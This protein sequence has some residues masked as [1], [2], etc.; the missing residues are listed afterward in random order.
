MLAITLYT[1]FSTAVDHLAS[2]LRSRNQKGQVAAEYLG[3]LVVV[4]GIITVLTTQTHLGQAIGGKLT[5][6]VTNIF[7]N[8]GK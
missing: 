4:A 6:V 7:G 8:G 3:V 2:T 5:E 1:Y